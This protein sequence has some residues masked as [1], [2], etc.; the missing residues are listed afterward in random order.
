MNL[1]SPRLTN[2]TGTFPCIFRAIMLSLSLISLLA[3][4]IAFSYTF[5]RSALPIASR[6]TSLAHSLTSSSTVY[7]LKITART[8]M[9]STCANRLPGQDRAPSE[10]GTNAPFE[11]TKRPSPASKDA[12]LGPSASSESD[13]L[14]LIVSLGFLSHRSGTKSSRS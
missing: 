4:A 1:S 5:L 7:V 14:D 12:F 13:P 2:R 10:N 8:A 6:S 3:F 11:G 9:I